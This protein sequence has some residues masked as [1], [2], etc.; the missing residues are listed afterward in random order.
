MYACVLVAAGS[1]TRANLGYNKL[2]YLVNQKPLFWYAFKPFYDRN[3]EMVL[4]V[5]PE[6][7]TFIRS[8]VPNDVKI[9]YGGKTRAESVKNG[10]QQVTEPYVMIHDAARVYIDETLIDQVEN[11]LA[12]HQACVLSK[13][14]TNTIYAK[15]ESLKVLDRRCLYEAETPQAFI[16]EEIKKAYE[17]ISPQATDDVSQYQMVY[18]HEVGL[19]LHE[20]NNSK[21]TYQKDIEQFEKEVENYMFKIGHSY[22][23]HALVEGRKLILGGIEIPFELGLLGH[24]DADVLLHAVAES[25][26]GALGLGDL[27]T[28]FPDT[29]KKFKDM[30]SKIIVSDVVKMM[31]NK[32]YKVSN[33]DCTIFA[34][35]PKLAPFI[36]DIKQSISHLLDAPVEAINV[37][38]ATN[39]KLD[40]IGNLKAMAA[41]ATILLIKGE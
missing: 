32:G 16:T 30:D 25:I 38:A 22:D 1:G 33:I 26:L 15:D 17:T 20:Q 11:G 24:S 28:F 34:E 2:R 12:I 35:K 39:E 14:V 37:K 4:V 7:E 19:V 18:N 27:G 23:I 6:D 36:G 9:V 5:N 8:Y 41:S 3:Y 13:R 10:L 21:I 29:D 40:S 31:K